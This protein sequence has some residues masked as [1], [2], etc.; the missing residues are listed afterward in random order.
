MKDIYGK[1]HLK[2]KYIYT[3]LD[4]PSDQT[5]TSDTLLWDFNI[6]VGE[7]VDDFYEFRNFPEDYPAN[8]IVFAVDTIEIEGTFRRRIAIQ[9][10]V[11]Q[12][13]FEDMI[14]TDT[15]YWI[16]GIG[17]TAGFT[18]NFSPLP[19]N[20]AGQFAADALA[21]IF[22]GD[23]VIYTD[24]A[25]WHTCDSVGDIFGSIG[26]NNF[27]S[28]FTKVLVDNGMGGANSLMNVAQKNYNALPKFNY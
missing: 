9:F 17:S 24:D 22:K 8:S 13:D 2:G 28:L 10:E 6:E 7:T 27:F 1:I 11:F 16:E 15:L 3:V 19:I 21:C 25:V 5:I 4:N 12:W 14:K 20:I 18:L 23:A 26:D